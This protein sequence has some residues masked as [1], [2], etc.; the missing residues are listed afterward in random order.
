MHKTLLLGFTFHK[1]FLSLYVP[2]TSFSHETVTCMSDLLP[3]PSIKCNFIP[4]TFFTENTHPT[5]LK[6]PRTDLYIWAILF[7]SYLQSELFFSLLLLRTEI[8]AWF[9]LPFFFFFLLIRDV[10]GCFSFFVMWN[11][12][13]YNMYYLGMHSFASNRKPK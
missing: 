4:H 7:S 6:Q 3:F 5:F 9:F 12:L 11:I 2:I 8:F 1:T 10:F 13:C